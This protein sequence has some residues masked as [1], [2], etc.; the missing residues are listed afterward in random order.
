MEAARIIEY[1]IKIP[2]INSVWGYELDSVAVGCVLL[3]C[4]FEDDSEALE[5]IKGVFP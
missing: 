3:V 4:C 1:I 5:H 2:Y